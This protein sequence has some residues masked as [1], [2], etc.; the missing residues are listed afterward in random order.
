MLFSAAQRISY[1]LSLLPMRAFPHN[2]VRLNSIVY[3]VMIWLRNDE[4]RSATA[5]EACRFAA[6]L[7]LIASGRPIKPIIARDIVLLATCSDQLI[8][9]FNSTSSSASVVSR[10]QAVCPVSPAEGVVIDPVNTLHKRHSTFVSIEETTRFDMSDAG[11]S[12]FARHGVVQCGP[13]I[14]NWGRELKGSDVFDF[15]CNHLCVSMRSE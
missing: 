3:Y 8:L 15:D 6:S 1:V 9:L 5:S 2:Y 12:M 14:G 11:L 10:L 7:L 13:L 4:P